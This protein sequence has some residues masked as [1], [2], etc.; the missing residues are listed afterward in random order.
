LGRE[1]LRHQ[2]FVY[3]SVGIGAAAC[4]DKQAVITV[5]CVPYGRAAFW[6]SMISSALRDGTILDGEV[7]AIAAPVSMVECPDDS[8][9]CPA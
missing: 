6:K 8:G 5:G 1:H 3:A 7:A 2:G 4:E 9:R